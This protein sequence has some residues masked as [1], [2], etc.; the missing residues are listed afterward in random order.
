MPERE[1]HQHDFREFND[2]LIAERPE[3]VSQWRIAV[4]EWEADMSVTN[5]FGATTASELI[6]YT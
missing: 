4:E 1:R 5:P 3:E 6:F 2:T